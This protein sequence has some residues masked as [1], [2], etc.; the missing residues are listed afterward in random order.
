MTAAP[1]YLTGFGNEFATESISGALPGEKK[2]DVVICV[3]DASNLER[4]LQL[5]LQVIE[6]QLPTIVALNMVDMAEKAGLRLDPAK[7]SEELG[8]PVIPMQASAGKGI[9]ELK[10]AL[11]FP[12]P[13][14]PQAKWLGGADEAMALH[15]A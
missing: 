2:P 4:H 1:A 9:I 11:R 3:V 14:A 12:F 13:S 10:Q 5:V 6:L 8:V 15:A 7:L